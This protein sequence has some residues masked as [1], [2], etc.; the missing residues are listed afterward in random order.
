MVSDPNLSIFLTKYGARAVCVAGG[1]V[2]VAG[3]RYDQQKQKQ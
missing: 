2:T 3:V 1:I